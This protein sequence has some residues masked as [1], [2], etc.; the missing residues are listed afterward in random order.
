MVLFTL[1][2]VRH[3]ETMY[4]RKGI[5]Q[6]QTD[7]PLSSFGERQAEMVAARLQNERFTHIFSSDLCRATETARI[8]SEA[9]KVCRC[10]VTMDK[11]LRERKFGSLE[12]KSKKE[13]MQQVKKAKRRYEDFTPSGA[14][15]Y[16]EVRERARLFFLDIC[17]M[18]ASYEYQDDVYTPAK[19]KRRHGGSLGRNSRHS[20][21]RLQISG[22]SQSFCGSGN[23]QNIINE[24]NMESESSDDEN[25][26]N[27]VTQLNFCETNS[28]MSMQDGVEFEHSDKVIPDYNY[29]ECFQCSSDDSNTS[30][31][32]KPR[33]SIKSETST[34]S[35]VDSD[36]SPSSQGTMGNDSDSTLSGSGSGD[37]SG[38]QSVVIPTEPRKQSQ[39]FQSPSPVKRN[40]DDSY[41]ECPNV[42]LTFSPNAHNF[43]SISS[44]SSGRNSSFDDTDSMPQTVAD[45]LVV[46]HGGFIKECL[47]FFVEI[48]DCKIPGMRGHALKV[49]PN[50]SVSKFNITLDEYTLTP[51]VTCVTIHDKDHLIG[52]DLP[53]TKGAF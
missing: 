22:R 51:T 28:Y 33:G 10:Q 21:K 35:E 52:L 25:E 6:G 37:C 48:L 41:E 45:I 3:G 11:R 30:A 24:M 8:I 31:D 9:N 14:E 23:I 7:I 36:L 32:L 20:N 1:T 38:R 27:V 16:R 13:L 46:S 2:L 5:I 53:S 42:S 15:S 12:G 47:N 17:K 39:I 50:C 49:C 34:E 26:N 19:I 44:I 29:R 18:C 40:I 43:S 4:N